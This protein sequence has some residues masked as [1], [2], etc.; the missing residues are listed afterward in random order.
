MDET[1]LYLNMVP[2][3][4]IAQNEEKNLVIRTQNQE[5]IRITCLLTVCTDGD[6]L[7]PYIIFKGKNINNRS[8]NKIKNNIY[9]KSKKIFKKD[10]LKD[11]Y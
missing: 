6:K 4:V 1:P 8:M 7:S 9:I 2:N 3:K 5:R 11:F 10:F